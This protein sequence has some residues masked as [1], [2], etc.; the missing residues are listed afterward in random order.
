MSKNMCDYYCVD[1]GVKGSLGGTWCQALREYLGASS[2][3]NGQFFRY[4]SAKGD[5]NGCPYY[6]D[7]GIGENYF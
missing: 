6:R 3:D 4:Y 2:R 5:N 7:G 1:Y